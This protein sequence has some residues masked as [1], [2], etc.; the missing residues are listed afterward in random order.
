MAFSKGLSDRPDGFLFRSQP[1]PREEPPFPTF[2]SP[3][4]PLR[5]LSSRVNP[6]T[7]ATSPDSRGSLQRRFTTNALPTLS[8]L[9]QQRR[10]A[11]EPQQDY[12][13]KVS[14]NT[15]LEQE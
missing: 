12:M 2:T 10:A 4:S 13:S 8:P 7:L 6:S 9:G 11:A 3:L 5:N 14:K 15:F 1:S